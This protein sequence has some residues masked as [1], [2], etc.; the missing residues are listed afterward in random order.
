M[1]LFRTLII[2]LCCFA[3]TNLTAQKQQIKKANGFYKLNKFKDAITLYEE[4]LAIKDNLSASTKLAYCYRMT[5]QM[6]KAEEWY[7]KVVANDKAKSKSYFYYAE[8]L[9]SNSKYDEAKSWFLKYNEK[10]PNDKN[11][12]R[13]A[14]AC[15]KVKTLV[16]YFKNV[17]LEDFQHNSDADDSAP[18]F[19]NDGIVFTSDRS[20]GMNPLKQKSGWTGRDFQR[21][22]FSAQQS[23]GSYNSPENFSKKINDLNKHCGP[24]SFTEDKKTV[25]F[26]RTG[27]TAGKDNSYNIQLYSAESDDGKKWKNVKILPFCRTDFNYMHPAISPDGQKL[28]FVSDR[29]GGLGGTDIYLSTK[30]GDSWGSP[31]NLGPVI[32]TPANEAFPFYHSSDKLFFCSKGHLSF[33]GFDI[34]FSN[35]KDNGTWQKPVN[36]GKPINSS[37]DDISISLDETMDSGIFA[38]SRN[39]GDDDVYIFKVMEGIN[40]NLDS[41]D[42]EGLVDYEK[43]VR[44]EEEEMMT[45]EIPSSPSIR[46]QIPNTETISNNPVEKKEVEERP[47]TNMEGTIRNDETLEKLREEKI[48]ETETVTKPAIKEEIVESREER[49]A[50]VESKIEASPARSG[51]N[52]I[53][54][55]VIEEPVSEQMET[56]VEEKI[57]IMDAP[58]MEEEEFSIVEEVIKEEVMEEVPSRSIPVKT[59]QIKEAVAVEKSTNTNNNESKAINLIIPSKKKKRSIK[60]KEQE[61]VKEELPPMEEI[62][63]LSPVIEETIISEPIEEIVEME[64]APIEESFPG[65]TSI[66]DQEPMET[67]PPVLL[68]DQSS[69]LAD[70]PEQLP[71]LAELLQAKQAIPAKGFIISGL[72]YQ[73]GSYLLSPVDTR[74]L[75]AVVDLMN[76]YPDIKVEIGSHTSALGDDV[77][78]HNLS[79]KRA[80]SIMAFLVYKGV[81]NDR[82]TAKGYGETQ[83]LNNCRNGVNCSR[84]EHQENDRVELR[85]IN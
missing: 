66:M 72:T 27:E 47:V 78:N 8:S 74:S 79:R 31:Q 22:Y 29:R 16:P 34:L 75:A 58:P 43:P 51:A 38:S 35:L 82:V 33:G 32:N 59:E 45:E 41:L 11:A 60:T 84:A 68:G 57:D 50:V 14:Y 52:E 67:E 30:K 55:G 23:D 15:D 39:G 80:M 18:L 54:T 17:S 24:V 76:M 61:Y 63:E 28:F 2:L 64:E 73:K 53:E 83:L 7:A 20:S 36:V 48:A 44:E 12:V 37:Y 6:V 13:M 21:V 81:S 5:N 77:N 49:I 1:N 4:A 3:A 26:T 42:F 40:A 9:M 62:I 56:V 46:S 65:G 10:E 70:V 71:I 69:A 25:I 19:F 85:V